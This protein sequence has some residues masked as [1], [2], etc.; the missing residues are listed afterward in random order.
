MNPMPI[1]HEVLTV[2]E[3]GKLLRVHS[4]T[5]YKLIREDKIPRFRVGSEWRFRTDVIVRWM[6]EKSM[7]GHH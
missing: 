5:V 1:D 7:G 3:V 2:Q 6:A 4:S